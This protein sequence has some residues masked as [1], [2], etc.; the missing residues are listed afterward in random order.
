MN[1][2]ELVVHIGKPKT[3]SS[4]IQSFL[5]RN[6]RELASRRGILYPNLK[7]EPF[8]EGSCLN[9]S[10]FIVKFA[11][12]DTA[13]RVVRAIEFARSRGCSMVLLSSESNNVRYCEIVS[14]VV[15]RTRVPVR[16]ICYVRRQDHLL[17]SAW[18]QWGLRMNLRDIE[19]Y[20]HKELEALAQGRKSQF[21]H[22]VLADWS[23]HVGAGA[24]IV[25]PYEKGQLRGEDVVTDFLSLIGIEGRQ[26]FLDRD[27]NAMDSNKG[28]RPKAMEFLQLCR[29]AM[30]PLH[31]N[32]MLELFYDA[33]GGGN[34]KLPFES[35][36]LLS[37][38]LRL[39]ILEACEPGNQ[40]VAREYL[41]REDGRLFHEPW[42][43]LDEPWNP[44]HLS[45][46]DAA[47]MLLQ[48]VL[49]LGRRNT[50]LESRV[51]G[52]LERLRQVDGKEACES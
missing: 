47:S 22:A 33:L 35:Y 7:A 26:G 27:D 31:D 43:R 11:A 12:A 13:E 21:D 14:A 41:G 16:V 23:E 51:H 48:V 1:N 42:P 39:R 5:D 50:A 45:P 18:K 19:A 17:E 4:A 20:M 38:A 9:H 32:R 24:V 44:V 36:R 46:E 28:F 15:K 52:I 6:R 8:D 30:G 3:G 10:S 49:S 25:R 34:Q 37:P 29:A 40:R 2:P